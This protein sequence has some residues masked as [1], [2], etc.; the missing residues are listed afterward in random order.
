MPKKINKKKVKKIKEIKSKIKEIKKDSKK[1][2][3][4]QEESEVE[5]EI[6][7]AEQESSASEFMRFIQ[8]PETIPVAETLREIPELPETELL[9]DVSSSTRTKNKQENIEE[10]VVSTP[11]HY[12]EFARQQNLHTFEQTPEEILHT[13]QIGFDENI[14]RQRR[15]IGREAHLINPEE[16]MGMQ[17]GTSREE[18]ELIKPGQTG[19]KQEADTLPFQNPKKTYEENL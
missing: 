10:Y 5:E 8:K 2:K 11:E 4:E 17:G 1:E 14:G 13:H 18:Y 6:E 12:K 15:V 3:Q 7:D 19:F 16:L 9:E